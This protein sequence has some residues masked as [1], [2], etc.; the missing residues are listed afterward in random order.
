ML[1]RRDRGRQ[2]KGKGDGERERIKVAYDLSIKHLWH[3]RQN[4]TQKEKKNIVGIIFF[5]IIESPIHLYVL[6]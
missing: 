4:A 3:R 5:S 2:I 1:R 6:I